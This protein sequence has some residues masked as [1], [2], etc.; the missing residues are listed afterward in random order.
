MKK[1]LSALLLATLA[2]SFGCG[3]KNPEPDLE[4]PD[5]VQ[6]NEEIN[7]QVSTI[8]GQNIPSDMCIPAW[9]LS[10]PV[11]ADGFYGS[12]QAKY[13]IPTLSRDTADARARQAI[14]STLETKTAG[15][16]NSFMQQ[17]G[18]GDAAS[19]AE[20]AESVSKSVSVASIQGAYIEQRHMCP[21]GTVYSLAFYPFE[22]YKDNIVSA[23]Q[24]QSEQASIEEK[25]LYDAFLAKDA[26]ERLDAQ[27]GDAF[28]E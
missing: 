16:V 20:F 2:T 4:I 17:S 12:G 22:L 21:D 8:T 28:A 6:V 7:E 27:I 19:T 14:G 5:A 1:V 24:S 15:M 3:S 11:S 25:N 10:P 13:A 26:L 9:E 23:A 18:S